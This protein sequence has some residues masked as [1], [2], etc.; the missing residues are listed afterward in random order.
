MV[1]KFLARWRPPSHF[2]EGARPLTEDEVARSI[3]CGPDPEVHAPSRKYVEAGYDE[4]FV[5]QV[6]D[7][8]RGFLDFYS[9]EL[10]PI[11]A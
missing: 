9:K 6:G 2:E 7:D 11:L 8:Q 5:A 4:I 10:R 3:T 1:E